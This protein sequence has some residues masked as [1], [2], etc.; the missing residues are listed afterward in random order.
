MMQHTH[1][2]DHA[3]ALQT[4]TAL[5]FEKIKFLYAGAPAALV[6]NT[7]LALILAGAQST[8]VAPSRIYGWLATFGAILLARLAVVVAW[9]RSGANA[10]N[11]APCWIRLF[12]IAAVATGM[13]WGLGAVLLFPGDLP[14]QVLLS[15]VLAG[16]SAGA[17]TLLAVDRISMRGFVAAA[18][19]PLM[20]RFGFEGGE[21][22][23][24]MGAMV[25]L[26][27]SIVAA[28]ASQ[29]GRTIYQNFRL[30]IK[31]EEHEQVLQESEARYRAVTYSANDAIVTADSAG[32]IVNWNRGAEIIFGYSETEIC[33][34]PLTLL[35][36]HRY[37][38]RHLAG[39]G[40]VLS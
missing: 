23:I 2:G 24:A 18:L 33:G 9:R 7:L 25:A 8:V 34:Q 30:R 29:T 31:A 15:F 4:T 20:V 26:F 1:P 40:R 11:C 36:P 5:Q 14:H 37:R 12:R 27:L 35:I 17:I 21:T 38:D 22:S 39:I 32:K 3:K 28:N 10:G 6:T 13:G 16:M 19:L